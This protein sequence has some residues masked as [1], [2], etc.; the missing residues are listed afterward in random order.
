MNRR[1]QTVHKRA[2]R[3]R[4]AGPRHTPLSVLS[5]TF[6]E[7]VYLWPKESPSRHWWWRRCAVPPA[8]ISSSVRGCLSLGMN[9]TLTINTISGH[10]QLSSIPTTNQGLWCPPPPPKKARPNQPGESR[11][12]KTSFQLICRCNPRQLL[13][14]L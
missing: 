13:R 11:M 8:A 14:S 10:D 9:H 5:S 12:W 3:L 6:L 4:E 7:A 1:P 2:H